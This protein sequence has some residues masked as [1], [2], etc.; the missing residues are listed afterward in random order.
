[1]ITGS[2]GSLPGCSQ[3]NLNSID[4]LPSI[5]VVMETVVVGETENLSGT[6]DLE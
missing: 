6:F 3:F 1:M 5:F 4:Y 2:D